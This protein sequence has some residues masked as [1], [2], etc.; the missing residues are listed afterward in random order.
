MVSEIQGK[1]KDTSLDNNPSLV[2]Y[3]NYNVQGQGISGN[4]SPVNLRNY[5]LLSYNNDFQKQGLSYL[6]IN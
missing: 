6:D 1:S 3:D 4:M 2:D 5:P